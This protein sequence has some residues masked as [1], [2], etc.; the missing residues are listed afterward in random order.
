MRPPWEF[1]KLKVHPTNLRGLFN[2]SSKKMA[3]PSSLQQFFDLAHVTFAAT[4]PSTEELQ[5]LQLAMGQSLSASP[6]L[7]IP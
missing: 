2:K 4:H 6:V 1:L 5:A 7:E 3:T